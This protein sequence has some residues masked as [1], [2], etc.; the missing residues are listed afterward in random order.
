[1]LAN[2]HDFLPSIFG[3]HI[4]FVHF[5]AET[6]LNVGHLIDHHRDEQEHNEHSAQAQ[7]DSNDTS[8][9]GRHFCFTK[10]FTVL[11]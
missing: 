2:V 10:Y 6:S 7:G 8:Q 9:F 5:K 1:M 4:E 3:N 11:Q